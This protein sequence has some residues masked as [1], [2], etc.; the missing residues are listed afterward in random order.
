MATEE[1]LIT[2]DT[3][4][5][6]IPGKIQD[7]GYLFALHKDDFNIQYA[8]ENLP[9]L[10]GIAI[11]Q[12][13]GASLEKLLSTNHIQL[14]NNHVAQIKDFAQDDPEIKLP[15]L[16]VKV[17]NEPW[18]L[19]VHKSGDFIVLELEPADPSLDIELQRLLGAS[20]SQILDSSNLQRSL[21]NAAGK[22]KEI[23]GY[24]RVM[25]YRFW[26]DGHGEVIAE[27]KDENQEAFLGLHY[28]A[29]DIPRQARALYKINLTRIIADTK[30]VPVQLLAAGKQAAGQP[31]DL[32][33]STLRSV[34]PIHL[35]Y[36]ANMGVMASYSIS[37]IVNGELWGLIACHNNSKKFIDYKAREGTKLIGQILSS[38]IELKE[39][40]QQKEELRQYNNTAN[41]ILRYLQSD[42]DIVTALLHENDNMLSATAATGAALVFDKKIYTLGFCPTNEQ[43]A[44]IVEWL[45]VNNAQQIYYNNSF[46]Q[47]YKPAAAFTDTACGLLAC[48]LSREMG[49][50]LLWFKPEII[51]TMNWAGNPNK[52]EAKEVNGKLKISPRRSFET[53][54][55]QVK[56]Y[57]TPWSRAEF[58]TVLKLRED[59]LQV[60]NQRANQIRILND[61]LQEAYDELD[62]FSFTISHDL[63][64]PLAAVKNYTEILLEENEDLS[65][66]Q[67]N[68]LR[69][70]VRGAA[71][72]NTLI[73]EVLGYSRIGRKPVEKVEVNIAEVLSDV[74]KELLAVYHA[75]KPEIII[76]NTLP[77][78]GDAT[79]LNQVFTNLLSNAV[80]YSSKSE[81][82]RVTVTAEEFP[83][84]V[85][86]RIADNGIG[87]DVSFGNQVFEI[88]KRLGNVS[89]YEGSGVG[90][91]IVKRIME[92]H[93]GKIWYESQL[94]V[95]TVF[96]IS[97]PK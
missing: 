81:H 47:E 67:V 48:T 27:A 74:K 87:M 88:F 57:A 39:A 4:P 55:E 75:A 29:S 5:I 32:T 41:A 44:G 86:Y 24:E 63:K 17:N 7:H 19:V 73:D 65:E 11:E 97:F 59:I 42:K 40:Q 52:P 8:S 33:Y 78:R 18:F 61:K 35:E 90:L 1:Q 9:A 89:G 91:S 45:R 71:K 77:V 13:L 64:T 94:G 49:E 21:Q 31:L 12:L 34:S 26:E 16:P 22:V 96:Y 37:L 54:T 36:L 14:R 82:P 58:T 72:M 20:V 51:Q 62:T 10:C 15:A 60:V 28:P 56:G 80:K 25:I 69:K 23:I 30:A 95:G 43:I 76:E 70:V 83:Q 3:E 68:T 79:M 50:Y 84:E 2:C 66:Y 85:T 46:P 6:H 53:W 93:H 38:S 92:K